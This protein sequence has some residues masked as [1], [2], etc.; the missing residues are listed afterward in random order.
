MT[1]RWLSLAVRDLGDGRR[2]RL[3]PTTVGVLLMLGGVL[4]G[5][6]DHFYRRTGQEPFD[7]SLAGFHFPL[8]LL[9]VPAIAVLAASDVVSSKREDGSIKV[10]LGLPFSRLDLVVGSFV[11]RAALLSGGLLGMAAIAGAIAYVRIDPEQLRPLLTL[12]AYTALYA[13]TFVA[14][15]VGFSAGSASSTRASAASFGAV[16]VFVFRAWSVVPIAVAYVGNGFQTPETAP[17]WALAWTNLNPAMAYQN[18]AVVVA[19]D[20]AALPVVSPIEPSDPISLQ[21][22]FAV[23]VF[24]GW[25]LLALGI[26]YGRLRRTDL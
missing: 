8:L 23:G 26:G 17:A 19:P 20:L 22:E 16:F 9:L 4:A 15:A 10:Y 13:A 12:F 14:I 7:L 3:L 5:S 25:I 18:A 21:P 11:G 2:A 24:V 6:Y 1:V